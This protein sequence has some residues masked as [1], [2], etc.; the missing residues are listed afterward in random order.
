MKG[1]KAE[2]WPK[3]D[4]SVLEIYLNSIAILSFTLLCLKCSS[5]YSSEI[6][7]YTFLFH[8]THL[9]FDTPN[10]AHMILLIME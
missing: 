8:T 6:I 7:W 9:E 3:G 10:Y 1:S 4:R 5:S 2:D